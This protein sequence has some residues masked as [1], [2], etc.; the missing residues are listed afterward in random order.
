MVESSEEAEREEVEKKEEEKEDKS[1][2]QK[3]VLVD[4]AQRTNLEL[5]CVGKERRRCKRER[6]EEERKSQSETSFGK[7]WEMAL[8][9]FDFSAELG[10][11]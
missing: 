4:K 1:E 2:A 7:V 10:V 3:M 11:Y 5:D 8:S 6:Q 9:S